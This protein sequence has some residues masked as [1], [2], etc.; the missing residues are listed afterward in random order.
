MSNTALA[1][2]LKHMSL[3]HVAALLSG[4]RSAVGTLS[5]V[6]RALRVNRDAHPVRIMG[7]PAS[8]TMAPVLVTVLLTAGSLLAGNSLTRAAS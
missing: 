7:F 2:A 1:S 3:P 5:G 8:C 6:I 4:I